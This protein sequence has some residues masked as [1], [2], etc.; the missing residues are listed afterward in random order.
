MIKKPVKGKEKK[1]LLYFSVYFSL[2][3]EINNFFQ[4]TDI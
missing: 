3:E 2:A 1:C 4:N